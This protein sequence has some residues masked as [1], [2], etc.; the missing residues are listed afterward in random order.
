M[1]C[2]AFFSSSSNALFSPSTRAISRVRCP[3]SRPCRPTSSAASSIRMASPQSIRNSPASF[4][5]STSTTRAPP[6][7]VPATTLRPSPENATTTAPATLTSFASLPSTAPQ[8]RT[9]PST[10]HPTRRPPAASQARSESADG[11]AHSPLLNQSADPP[12]G[13]RQIRSTRSA[14]ATARLCPSGDHRAGPPSMKS[15]DPSHADSFRLQ[16]PPRPPSHSTRTQEPSGDGSSPLAPARIPAQRPFSVPDPAS[17]KTRS[18][19][20]LE[21]STSRAPWI[22]AAIRRPEA[23]SGFQRVPA[24]SC[25]FQSLTS[26]KPALAIHFPSGLPARAWMLERCAGW[27]ASPIGPRKLRVVRS[28]QWSSLALLHTTARPASTSATE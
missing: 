11:E 13:R 18:P 12:A 10:P 28:Y 26:R 25:L 17:T 9:L 5:G 4:P 3:A 15:R 6:S 2:T 20:A 21:A 16:T 23:G 1:V 14:Q 19:A 7:T 27:P 24:G 8:T 22:P